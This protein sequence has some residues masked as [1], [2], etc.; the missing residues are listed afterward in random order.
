MN[1]FF[2]THSFSW[3]QALQLPILDLCKGKDGLQLGAMSELYIEELA[4]AGAAA[5]GEHSW[6]KGE[7]DHKGKTISGQKHRR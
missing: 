6:K 4:I 3:S 1:Y 2:R 7:G 5:S